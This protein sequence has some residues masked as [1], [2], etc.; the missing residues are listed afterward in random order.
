[1]DN[2]IYFSAF[3]TLHASMDLLST[4]GR[5]IPNYKCDAQTD[6]VAVIAGPNS[7]TGKQMA[8][9]LRFYKLPQV[10]YGSAP[11]V[12]DK[13]Q[14]LFF[15]RMFPSTSLQDKG[16]LQ[17]LLH[18]RWTWIGA[19][20]V[21][22]D[23]AQWLMQNVL[24]MFTQSGICFDFIEGFPEQSFANF[25]DNM[26]AEEIKLCRIVMKSTATAVLLYGAS[27]TMIRLRILMMISEL[28]N[29]PSKTIGKVWIMDAQMEFTSFAFQTSWEV[30]SIHGA[31]SVASH[32]KQMLGF[33]KFLQMKK[34]SATTEDG[35]IRDFWEQA[36]GCSC[37][38][39]VANSEA[40][41]ACSGEEKLDSLPASTFETD[42]TSHSYSIYN[43]VYVVAHALQAMQS[44]KRR[45]RAMVDGDRQKLW[46]HHPWQLHH[47]LGHISFNNS[48]GDKVSLDENG[49]VHA[50][51]D[52][53][54]FV[55]YSNQSFHRVKVG[56]IDPGFHKDKIFTTFEDTLVWPS[57]FNQSVPLSLCNDN[58][59]SGFRKS[60]REGKPSCCYDCLPCPKGKISNH[61]DMDDC[62]LCTEDQFSNDEH[63]A[64]IPKNIHFLSYKEPL[65]ISLAIVA[66]FFS[67]IT[68][69]VFWAF[70]KHRD[71]PIVKAN[72]REL[73]YTLLIS[74]LLCFLCTLL[75]IGQP[76]KVVCLFRQTAFGIIFSV[77]VS[78]VLAKTITVVLAFL[79]TKPGSKMR[80]W[81]GK[82][83]AS[84]IVV[85]CCLTQVVI[86]TVWLAA[87]PPFP[88]S[89]MNAMVEEIVLE[90][91]EGSSAMFYCVLG[92][93]GFLSIAALMVAF[94]ARKLPDSFNEAKFISFS[95]LVF[96]SVWVSFV[97]S[98]LS[99]KG[100]YT[101]AVE[102][103]A[104][105]ASSAGLLLFIFSPKCYII[106]LKP[107]LNSKAHL[108]GKKKQRI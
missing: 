44:S 93:L 65:G 102:I 60:R 66:V 33:Q 16:I 104:I 43:A 95:M 8:D 56:R 38:N 90:C 28:Q 84:T 61:T 46:S 45:H 100:K 99:T 7:D 13:I 31:I 11:T 57:V 74:L 97:P 55:T 79:S 42:I 39:L 105:L 53:V 54:N 50:G 30:H 41:D 47:F 106:L 34:C 49:V 85:S 17:L 3:W 63:K 21:N 48:A 35:F 92:F 82:Q 108:I 27:E 24:P 87:S 22:S 20:F 96:C 94:L 80:K 91:N 23:G 77:A 29:I 25:V 107:E 4:P 14:G 32:S 51:F 64:C 19:L 15:Y 88:H 101:V 68:A 70:I 98:Y 18:F 71:T 1:M 67:S 76:Q 36:F 62:I 5:F 2:P 9:I 72:N 12:N 59:S 10:F 40:E 86:C 69:L 89:D 83:L 75:F 52:I 73:T 26:L 78:S 81:M 6:L 58:C 37:F 103:F